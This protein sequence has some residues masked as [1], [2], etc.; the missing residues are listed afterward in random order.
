MHA[1]RSHIPY[2]RVS[3]GRQVPK[4][5]F[6]IRFLEVHVILNQSQDVMWHLEI[7]G[8]NN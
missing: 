4:L 5:N 8:L 2:V 3:F 6:H 7:I 1:Y